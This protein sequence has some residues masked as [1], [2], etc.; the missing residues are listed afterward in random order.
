MKQ[1][2]V[3]HSKDFI[4]EHSNVIE[5]V[6]AQMS[7]LKKVYSEVPNSNDLTTVKKRSSLEG[8]PLK[9]RLTV[10]GN[11]NINVNNPL[12]IDFSTMLGYKFNKLLELGIT[13]THRASL[14]SENI[15]SFEDEQVYGYTAYADHKVF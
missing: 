1:K 2:V 13:G 8:Q 10:G 14:G 5:D 9:K 11:F 4:S 12:T 3:M 7:D 15:N 6:Q